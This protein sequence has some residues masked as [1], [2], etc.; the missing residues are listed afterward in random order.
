MVVGGGGGEM[1]Y[2]VLPNA[3]DTAAAGWT[4]LVT[5]A[6]DRG[7]GQGWGQGLGGDRGW[8][9]GWGQGLGGGTGLVLECKQNMA[10]CILCH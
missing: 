6:G 1:C 10:V 5:G 2:L 3:I 4:G 9:Q 7:W 8:G